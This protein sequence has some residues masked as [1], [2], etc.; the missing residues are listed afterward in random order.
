[1]P[2]LRL[3]LMLRLGLYGKQKLRLKLML[4]L[5]LELM[6]K[7]SPKQGLELGPNIWLD[8]MPLLRPGLKK[9]LRKQGLKKKL[10][11]QEPKKKLR[12]GPLLK[13]RWPRRSKQ[14]S[15]HLKFNL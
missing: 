8:R 13:H 6:L 1:M 10:M 2:R 5:R 14:L 11:K 15:M 7:L 12:I 9:K 3:E 4:K